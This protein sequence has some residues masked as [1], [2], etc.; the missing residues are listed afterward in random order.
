[1]KANLCNCEVSNNFFISGSS[2][3]HSRSKE[4]GYLILSTFNSRLKNLQAILVKCDCVHLTIHYISNKIEKWKSCKMWRG[5]RGRHIELLWGVKLLCSQR[6]LENVW[7]IRIKSL[8]GKTKKA[9]HFLDDRTDQQ[10]IH[11][12]YG[13]IVEEVFTSLLTSWSYQGFF[14][15]I[16]CYIPTCAFRTI[17]IT[18][19]YVHQIQLLEKNNPSNFT[20]TL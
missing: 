19:Q 1:M 18:N 7:Q 16:K 6:T 13:E 2:E 12:D 10:N 5:W 9:F 20:G 17:H 15:S 14:S 8:S 4:S 11:P 3:L